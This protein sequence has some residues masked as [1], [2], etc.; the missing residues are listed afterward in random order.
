[1]GVLTSSLLASLASGKSKRVEHTQRG[2]QK[3]STGFVTKFVAHKFESFGS[4][5]SAGQPPPD[6][7]FDFLEIAEIPM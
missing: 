5:H 2:K 6:H 1:L 7:Q 3:N 4:S